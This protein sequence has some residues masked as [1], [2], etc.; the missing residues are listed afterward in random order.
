MMTNTTKNKI[1]HIV[2]FIVLCL[3]SVIIA[4]P[5]IWMILS[6]F[7]KSEEFYYLVPKLLPE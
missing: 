7:K 6:S 1:G 5:F 4:F 3:L 2:L